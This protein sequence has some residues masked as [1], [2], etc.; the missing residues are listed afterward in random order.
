MLLKTSPQTSANTLYQ[1]A[2]TVDKNVVG[3][4]NFSCVTLISYI[5]RMTLTH[6]AAI[7][8]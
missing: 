3:F 5:I 8:V 7:V 2:H 1:A 6:V 4:V